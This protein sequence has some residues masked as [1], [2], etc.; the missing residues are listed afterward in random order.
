MKKAPCTSRRLYSFLTRGPPLIQPVAEATDQ[1][2]EG[3]GLFLPGCRFPEIPASQSGR[4][5]TAW[6]SGL[7]TTGRLDFF[8]RYRVQLPLRYRPSDRYRRRCC[9]RRRHRFHPDVRL[10]ID[11]RSSA[12]LRYL[13][14]PP[15]TLRFPASS[16]C[17]PPFPFRRSPCDRPASV[18]PCRVRPWRASLSVRPP[19]TSTS[20]P[21][22]GLLVA[23]SARRPSP[24]RGDVTSPPVHRLRAPLLAQQGRRM[25]RGVDIR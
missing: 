22:L 25:M 21:L 4:V 15:S 19:R 2:G 8:P 14:S 3:P 16:F 18:P 13:P 20:T 11:E 7:D 24:R 17:R 10:P 6:A 1:T 23:S 5:L 9:F 12:F